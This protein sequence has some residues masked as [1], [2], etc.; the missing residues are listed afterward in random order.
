[1]RTEKVKYVGRVDILNDGFKMPRFQY[2]SI[3]QEYVKRYH[4]VFAI[5]AGLSPCARDL[6]EYLVNTMNEDNIVTTNEYT[7]GN[8]LSVL[9]SATLTSSGDFVTYSD[10]NVKKAIQTLVDRNCLIKKGRGIYIVNPEIYFNPRG[11][12]RD[13]MDS[14][15]MIL[16]FKAGTRDVNMQTLYQVSNDENISTDEDKE[17]KEA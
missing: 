16:E 4:T 15:K 3:E 8:F 7:R 13:R 9:K 14:I 10:S 12:Q 6:M 1:M 2:Q 11:T 5:L 17:D